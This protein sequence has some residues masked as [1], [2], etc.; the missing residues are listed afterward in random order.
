ML[1]LMEIEN[2]ENVLVALKIF[3]ELHK[4]YRPPYSTDVDVSRKSSSLYMHL[5]FHYLYGHSNSSQ[6]CH[7]LLEDGQ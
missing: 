3:M 1:K 6:E 7:K 2:E 5:V 4:Q